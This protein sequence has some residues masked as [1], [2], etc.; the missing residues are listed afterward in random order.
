MSNRKC[1]M[2]TK[3]VIGRIDK[4][5]CSPNCKNSYHSQLKR[6]T[7]EV[8]YI[9]DQ[10][11]H[12]NRNI[13]L[14]LLGEEKRKLYIHKF[15][16]ERRKFNFKHITHLK[17]SKHGSTFFCVYEFVWIELDNERIYIQKHSLG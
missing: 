1:R 9:T 16:L 7:R 4:L 17:T 11:L 6:V 8:T 3:K 2:C 12:R 14:L 10:I 5:F 13:L 15:E